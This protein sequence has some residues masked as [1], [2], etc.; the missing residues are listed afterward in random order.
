MYITGYQFK[1]CFVCVYTFDIVWVPTSTCIQQGI[2]WELQHM[3][4]LAQFTNLV[5]QS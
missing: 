2:D 1:S 4:Q 5:C 3:I